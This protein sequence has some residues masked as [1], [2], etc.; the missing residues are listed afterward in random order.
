MPPTKTAVLGRTAKGAILL[1]VPKAYSTGLGLEGGEQVTLLLGE[2]LVVVPRP[3]PQ[4][5]RV[6][7]AME[8]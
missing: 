1:N 7:R 4:A 5:D 6:R 2:V 3:S 8:G